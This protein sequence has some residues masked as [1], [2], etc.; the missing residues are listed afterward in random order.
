MQVY[1]PEL[2]Q[3]AP[4]YCSKLNVQ[5]KNYTKMPFW[6][7]KL[8]YSAR[9]FLCFLDKTVLSASVETACF[10]NFFITFTSFAY[11]TKRP[12]SI[13][14]TLWTNCPLVL[15]FP[16]LP[17]KDPTLRPSLVRVPF[18]LEYE[19]SFV[20]CW[21]PPFHS[22]RSEELMLFL[23]LLLLLLVILVSMHYDHS[24]PPSRIISFLSPSISF[25]LP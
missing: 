2:H 13:S 1:L 18:W 25:V 14:C 20:F 16:T 21:R 19:L 11:W 23:H 22:L 17:E 7:S 3:D 24:L 8:N 4:L 12:L 15:G 9:H 6:Y 5:R 10:C